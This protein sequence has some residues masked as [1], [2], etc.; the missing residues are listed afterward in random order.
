[1]KKSGGDLKNHKLMRKFPVLNLFNSIL[2]L[3]EDSAYLDYRLHVPRIYA[4]YLFTIFLLLTVLIACG[5][6][7]YPKNNL[8]RTGDTNN[9]IDGQ[10]TLL[11]LSSYPSPPP[12][13]PP[14]CAAPINCPPSCAQPPTP[15]DLSTLATKVVD[16]ADAIAI[17]KMIVGLDVNS[18]GQPV[19]VYQAY[20]ADVDGN[21]KVELSDAIR[22]LKHIVGLEKMKED[23]LFFN[24]ANGTPVISDKLNPGVPPSLTALVGNSTGPNVNIFGALR[25]DV[26]AS[27]EYTYTWTLIEA[28]SISTEQA[29]GASSSP[30]IFSL[31][32]PGSYQASVKITDENSY[33]SL[34]TASMVVCNSASNLS[35]PFLSCISSSSA[36]VDSWPISTAFPVGKNSYANKNASDLL[37]TQVPVDAVA[38]KVLVATSVTFGDF[39]QEGQYAAFVVSTDGVAYFLR[40]K[41]SSSAWV[42]D[43]ARLFGTG[44][45]NTCNA[46]YAITADFNADGKPDVFLSCSGLSNQL[47]FISSGAGYVRTDTSIPVDGNRAAA[48]DIN[49]DGILDLVLTNKNTVPQI[50]KGN[51]GGLTFSYQ[52]S[53]LNTLSTNCGGFLFPSSIDSVFLVPTAIGR[54][55]LVFGGVAAPGGRPYIQL[56]KLSSA[57]YFT[58]CNSNA[59]GFQQINDTAFNS[60]SLRDIFFQN[61][62]FYLLTQSKLTSQ[63]QF[64]R[65]T[66]DSS[67]NPVLLATQRL[68]E[69]TTGQGLPQ[70]F[71]FNNTGYFQPYEAGCNPSRCSTT[72]NILTFSAET[73]S[74]LNPVKPSRIVAFGDA[75]VD[76]GQVGRVDW[77]NAGTK[78]RF[79]VNQVET[80]KAF[81]VD[82]TFIEAV[83]SYFSLGSVS[84]ALDSLKAG[85][86]P[87]TGAY[88]YGEFGAL[89]SGAAAFGAGTFE[90]TDGTL[91]IADARGCQKVAANKAT[92]TAGAAANTYCAYNLEAQIDLFLTQGSPN[93]NDLFVISIGTG[94]IMTTGIRATTTTPYEGFDD[95]RTLLGGTLTATQINARMQT[96]A[97][98]LA[99]QVKRLTDAGAKFV[100]ILGPP[101]LGRSPWATETGNASLLENLSYDT[102]TGFVSMGSEGLA[103]IQAIFGSANSSPVLYVEINGMVNTLTDEG[104]KSFFSNRTSP[105]C[106]ATSNTTTTQISKSIGTGLKPAVAVG[107]VP[108]GRLSAALCTTATNSGADPKTYIYADGVNFTP[109]M[110]SQFFSLVLDRMRLAAWV[111]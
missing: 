60:S 83:S 41:N 71:K 51:V 37:R 73:V 65:Y 67:G 101:N 57:P 11:A 81:N 96:A 17:L 99:V 64:A 94:D 59:K 68:S 19:T 47:M 85:R 61:G 43:S 84:Y 23:W 63:I 29:I 6:G 40:W 105:I 2:Y 70:Q 109:A 1:L 27:S 89:V 82:T 26:I 44:A 54:V 69:S 74:N 108:A 80:A 24:R 33:Y 76:V 78:Y 28:P 8:N 87:S 72:S 31:K 106:A 13:C 10:L 30:A 55:D 52:A 95:L 22:V 25:G 38:G 77:N 102:G 5:G 49:G 7:D 32:T 9:I 46:T 103:R 92:R 4:R 42:D 66:I 3:M 86:L 104:N 56:Q 39:F 79:T 50:W 100:I 34:S 110:Q 21:G 62:Y 97:D 14:D 90:P 20:A 93:S 12:T 48:A 58:T 35:S 111:N 18:N 36:D 107:A 91:Q 16:L 15:P 75:L 98:A 45:R 88:S 53:W